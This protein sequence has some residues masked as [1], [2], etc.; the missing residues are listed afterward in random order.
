M[1]TAHFMS[2]H[3]ITVVGQT[4]C[5]VPLPPPL[6]APSHWRL[7]V[8]LCN[9]V[10]LWPHSNWP[11]SLLALHC[12]IWAHHSSN[13]LARFLCVCVCVS[14]LVL[15]APGGHTVHLHH[16]LQYKVDGFSS[17]ATFGWNL[18]VNIWWGLSLRFNVCCKSGSMMTG[19]NRD[20]GSVRDQ[21][22]GPPSQ[23]TRQWR[24]FFFLRNISLLSGPL[25]TFNI[26]S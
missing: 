26:E 5:L 13:A 11:V 1:F 25:W 17:L 2:R 22:A 23:K 4:K 19:Y 15:Q 21:S 14:P 18:L 9:T 6:L 7:A 3:Q 8:S 10:K 16:Y 12:C 24:T 20:G